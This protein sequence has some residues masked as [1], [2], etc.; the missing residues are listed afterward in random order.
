MSRN[1]AE[2]S[3]SPRSIMTGFKSYRPSRFRPFQRALPYIQTTRADD[4]PGTGI[5]QN[6]LDILQDSIIISDQPTSTLEHPGVQ[7]IKP[8]PSEDYLEKPTDALSLK[9]YLST[10]T[11]LALLV[12]VQPDANQELSVQGLHNP[13]FHLFPKLPLEIQ[14]AVWELTFPGP[15]EVCLGDY[16][17]VSQTGHAHVQNWCMQKPVPVSLFVSQAS[18]QF[19]MEHFRIAV[20]DPK[21][22]PHHR[23]I[24]FRSK[25]DTFYLHHP[26]LM[27]AGD[28]I[29]LF[30][31]WANFVSSRNKD[32]FKF[33]TK[34][35]V[36]EFFWSEDLEPFLQRSIVAGSTTEYSF[37]NRWLGDT[38]LPPKGPFSWLLRFPSLER[39]VIWV[40]EEDLDWF[41][42]T[43]W[44]E[45]AK[46][47]KLQSLE[48][49]KAYCG[50]LITKYLAIHSSRFESGRVPEIVVA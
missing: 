15:R 3:R 43:H 32:A 37:Q 35:D 47:I 8:V 46:E 7:E 34:L 26:C 5:P 40:V 38:F 12:F 1:N 23:S 33:I 24:C 16:C 41:Q 36:H 42:I 27:S 25:T 31:R 14:Q 49:K 21:D 9:Q 45:N 30:G 20:N 44:V 17:T 10:I 29:S 39:V 19:T 4:Q 11:A 50:Y 28:K 2:P 13:V 6:F 22:L 48:E 18:R